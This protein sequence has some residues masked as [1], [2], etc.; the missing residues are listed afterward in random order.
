MRK[1]DHIRFAFRRRAAE[2]CRAWADAD[3]G[4]PEAW[5]CLGQALQG[6]GRHRDAIAAFRKAKQFDPG[7]RSLD[8][9]IERSQRAIVAE[10]QNRYDR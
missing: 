10:F 1:V 8:V 6:V 9:A 3:L 2:V 7:D 4:N 5:R